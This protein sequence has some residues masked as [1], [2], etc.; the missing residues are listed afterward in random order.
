[1]NLWRRTKGDYL[2]LGGFIVLLLIFLFAANQLQGPWN[3][4]HIVS[5]PQYISYPTFSPP[6]S[7]V[8]PTFAITITP[9]QGNCPDKFYY[10][11]ND[12]FAL[13][14]P[15]E[16]TPIK[17]AQDHVIYDNDNG[18]PEKLF[19]SFIDLKNSVERINIIPRF[20]SA[21]QNVQ[22]PCQTQEQ[23]ILSGYPAK[24]L[25]F[26]ESNTNNTCGNI[27]S[28]ATILNDNQIKRPSKFTILY[29]SDKQLHYVDAYYILE[30]SLQIKDIN[31]E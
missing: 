12:M 18:K 28:I 26:K 10:Y 13:C 24:R 9:V 25:T 17:P 14:Y 31:L 2:L 8:T 16:L 7:L 4:S 29:Q 1:M 3:L 27:R 15:Q 6:G 23:I 20:S 11:Q 5:K 19:I 30:K 21:G 22:D